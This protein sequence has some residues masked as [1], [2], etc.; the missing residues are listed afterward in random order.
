MLDKFEEQRNKDRQ[1]LYREREVQNL[2][3][4]IYGQIDNDELPTEDDSLI[5]DTNRYDVHPS[6][7]EHFT[8]PDL[9]KLLKSKFVT[10]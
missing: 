9:K 5:V 8:H 4:L 1:S 6:K 3:D 2:R 7:L 10:G